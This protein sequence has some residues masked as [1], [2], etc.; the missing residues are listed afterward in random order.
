M[1]VLAAI[2]LGVPGA[3]LVAFVTVVL[4]FYHYRKGE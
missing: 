3:F 2:C 1:G 4:I